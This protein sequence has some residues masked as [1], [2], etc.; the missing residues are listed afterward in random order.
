MSPDKHPDLHA[1][2]P[3]SPAVPQTEAAHASSGRPDFLLPAT[4]DEL[5]WLEHYRVLAKLGEG[6]M[7]IVFRAED[8]HLKRVVALK[9]L[10]P[11]SAADPA[12]RLR[13]VREAQAM[14]AVAH[15]HVVT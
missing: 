1:T 15:D 14:A 9:V 8:T 3:S 4:G 10:Q 11:A 12:A 2:I 6:G 5:G 7:G 13:F